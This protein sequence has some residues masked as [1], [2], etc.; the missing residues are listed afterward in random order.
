[1][2]DLYR[3]FEANSWEWNRGTL[4]P[5]IILGMWGEDGEDTPVW[6]LR[7]VYIPEL[8]YNENNEEGDNER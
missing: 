2:I 5:A 7:I 4:P 8:D 6:G 1:M 3:L